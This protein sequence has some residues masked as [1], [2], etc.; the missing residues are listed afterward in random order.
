MSAAKIL[1]IVTSHATMGDSGRTTGVWFEEL[2]TP[3]YT[4]VDA[5]VHVDIAS[6]AGGPVPFDPHSIDAEAD[7]PASVRRFRN[8]A[9]AMQQVE[10]SK[11]IDDVDAAPYSAIFLPGGHGTMWDLPASTKL[12]RL[13][14]DAWSQNKVLAAVCHGPAGLVNVK[15]ANGQPL[16]A[17]RKV[18]GF[19][20]SEEEAAGLTHAVPFL[21]EDRLRSLGAQY[22]SAADFQ[23]HAIRDGKLVTGQ[24]PASSEEAARLTLQAIA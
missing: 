9:H 16:V 22:V 6:I 10:A 3:Y 2:S 19:S 1:M 11:K 7:Q 4:F 8:D 18:T 13:L 5:G 12:A 14:S 23:P 15:D 24:N 21:L 20:N 17:A